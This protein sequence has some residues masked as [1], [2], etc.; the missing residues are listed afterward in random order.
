MSTLTSLGTYGGRTGLGWPGHNDSFLSLQVYISQNFSN[1][2]PLI[3]GSSLSACGDCSPGGCKEDLCMEGFYCPVGSLSA[4]QV[5][6]GGAGNYM[7]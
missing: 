3:F 5:E 4:R 1:S 7:S 2:N 6:C